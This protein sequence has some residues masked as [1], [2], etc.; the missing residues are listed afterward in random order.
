MSSNFHLKAA[1]KTLREVFRLEALRPGQREVLTRVFDGKNVL[2]IM[3]T[4][5]GKSLCYQIPALHFAGM[6]VVVSPLISLMKDQVDKLEAKGLDAAQLN[7]AVTQSEENE[8]IEMIANEASEFIFITPERATNAE[9][10][11]SLKD[12]SVSLFVV[13]EAHCVSQWGHDFRPAF[14][15][16]RETIKQLKNPQVLALTATATPEVVEDIKKQLG[17]PEMEIVRGGIFR[18]NLAFEVAHVT[19]DTEKRQTLVRIL[20]ET[21]GAKIIY[22]ATVKT[23]EEIGA[24][25]KSAGLEAEIYHGRLTAKRRREAQDAFL[26]GATETMIATNAFGMGIDK[27]DIRLVVHYQMPG[28]LEAYYQEAGRAGRDGEPA[29]CALLYDTRDRRTQ[30]F[31]LGGRYPKPDDILAI[32]RCL[33]MMNAAPAPVALAQ[34]QETCAGVAKTK[35]KV[36][37]SLFKDLKIVR[38]MR[39]AKFKLLKTDLGDAE[40]TEIAREYEEKAEKDRAKLE[41]MMLYAQSA[42]CR[43]RVLSEY[44]E[45]NFEQEKCDVCDNCARLVAERLEVGAP[46]AE[47]KIES[48]V[49]IIQKPE[50]QPGE[51]VR[52]PK[53]GEAKVKE[54]NGENLTVVLGNDETKIFKAEFVEKIQT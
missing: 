15:D 46:P 14:L 18:P 42:L 7:S 37:L 33:E 32:Y 39:G 50:F 47:P 21:E 40:L 16:L 2:A 53:H 27:P 13:D 44:F 25:L 43:W 10:L 11:E 9:F 28:T 19:S 35:M 34:I 8:S 54:M 23:A 5:A 20:N 22:A 29:R 17:T 45:E 24:F 30:Q 31:F 41:R 1:R 12:K 52:L 38:E 48:P 51:I 6:T 26:S 49:E 4:G 3:P 36:A